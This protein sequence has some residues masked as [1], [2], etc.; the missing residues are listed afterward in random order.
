MD[1]WAVANEEQARYWNGNEATH[2]LVPEESY[3]RMPAPFTDHL[4]TA[5]AS[6]GA[7]RVVDIGCGTGPT[8]RAAG[9]V[10]V[11][12]AVLGVDLSAAMLRQAAR[13]AHE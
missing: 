4:L 13:R 3:E 7:D 10:A 2:W 9:R 6:G 8:T 1:T 5:A 12:G 11:E